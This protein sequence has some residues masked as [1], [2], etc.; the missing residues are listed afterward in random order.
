VL[1]D[2]FCGTG[3]ILL[4]AGLIGAHIIGGDIEQKMIDGCKKTFEFYKMKKYRLQCCDIGEI[5]RYA[6]SVDA[7]VTDFPYGR[8]TTTKGERL[9]TLYDRAFASI[10]SLLKENGRAVIGVSNKEMIATGENHLLL[11]EVHAFRVHR[12]LT[13]YFVVYQKEP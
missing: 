2:P 1:F 7:V 4:E 12:S 11:L 3:G 13:R 8:S 10:S 9:S 6:S 5:H